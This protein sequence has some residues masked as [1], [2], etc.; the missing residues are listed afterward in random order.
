MSHSL[1]PKVKQELPETTQKDRS[2]TGNGSS[3]FLSNCSPEI[4]DTDWV[5]HLLQYGEEGTLLRNFYM[6]LSNCS[7]VKTCAPCGGDLEIELS[8]SE[9]LIL[10]N[11][12]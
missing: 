11:S 7:E 2:H 4:V 10:I 8:F 1:Y 3:H 6:N 12:N 9:K 5:C